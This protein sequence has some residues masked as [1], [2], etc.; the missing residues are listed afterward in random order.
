METSGRE[1][2]H[3]YYTVAA[4]R[5]LVARE[6][7]DQSTAGYGDVDLGSSGAFM[8]ID[9]DAFYNDDVS[10]HIYQDSFKEDI[11][12]KG[13]KSTVSTPTKRTQSKKRTRE[14]NEPSTSR[15]KGKKRKIAGPE[16]VRT[17]DEE[18][19]VSIGPSTKKRVAADSQIGDGM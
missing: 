11:S 6:N 19:S 3:R 18:P 7:L 4:Y 2:R 12:G 13:K 14:D 16:D 5:A 17:E 10:L 15:P 8:P 9:A 1:R